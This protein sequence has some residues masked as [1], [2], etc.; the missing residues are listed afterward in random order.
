LKK[1]EKFDFDAFIQAGY[2]KYVVK[3]EEGFEE[4]EPLPTGSLSL[5]VAIGIGGL[6][7]GKFTTIYGAE[8]SGKTSISLSIAKMIRTLGEE[9]LYIDVESGL[10]YPYVNAVVG[11]FDP[12]YLTIVRPETAEQSLEVAEGGIRS[13]KFGLIVLDSV[14]ALAPQKLKDDELGDD[15][16]A[17]LARMMAKFLP[18]NAYRL[19][20]TKTAF[21]FVNQ[22]RDKIG[23][24]MGGYT[25]P[26]GH[27]LYHQ[28]SVII[29]LG[30]G[31]P[32]VEGKETTG[33]ISKFTI[34]KNK[35]APPFKTGYIPLRFG[36]G[37]D[38][39]RDAL[40]FATAL[41]IINKSGN[42]Y[43]FEGERMGNG[44]NQASAY[45]LENPEILDKIRE[46]CYNI[47]IRDEEVPMIDDEE[48][49]EVQE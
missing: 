34:K 48:L 36:M 40:D 5:D 12:S 26:G 46:M 31:S 47:A 33:I 24:Y 11:G 8:S 6:P 1:E 28:C 41:G 22:V 30:K 45:L 20:E 13:K 10:D 44:A 21:L 37:I 15:N 2:S 27:A 25:M 16:V 39:G 35:V 18:R 42:W 9:T 4:A 23:S 19:K 38:V 14:G 17:L 43:S 29:F 3:E 7:R 32:N 49:E